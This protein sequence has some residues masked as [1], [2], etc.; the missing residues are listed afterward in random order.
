MSSTSLQL[1]LSVYMTRVRV[2]LAGVPSRVMRCGWGVNG[3]VEEVEGILKLWC[4]VV[5]VYA[6]ILLI[7]LRRIVHLVLARIK[8]LLILDFIVVLM[9]PCTLNQGKQ[10]VI[11]IIGEPEMHTQ[12][13]TASTTVPT[14]SSKLQIMA[15]RAYMQIWRCQRVCSQW[16]AVKSTFH[17]IMLPSPP[18]APDASCLPTRNKYQGSF[19]TR[20]LVLSAV[21]APHRMRGH[22]ATYPWG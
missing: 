17:R 9:S 2:P 19:K 16:S 8:L 4:C 1:P 13:N 11:Q 6:W 10:G 3:G 7:R 12:H 18:S 15:Q 5:G 21:T 20:Q 14:S 22:D